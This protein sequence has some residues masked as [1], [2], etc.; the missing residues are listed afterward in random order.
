MSI[1][2]TSAGERFLAAVTTRDL[3]G[4]CGHLHPEIDFR[5]MTPNRFWEADGPAG[6]ED[7]LRSWL[8]N[9]AREVESIEALAPVAVE[10]TQRVGWCVRGSGAEGPFVFEQQAYVR[11]RDGQVIWLRVMCSGPRPLD[12]GGSA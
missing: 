6:V 5:A 7:V 4:A 2:A 11:E 10:D 1:T 8:E 12:G 3:A 9:P